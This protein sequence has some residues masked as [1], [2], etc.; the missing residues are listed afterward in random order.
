[1]RLCYPLIRENRER[2]RKGRGRNSGKYFSFVEDVSGDEVGIK[3]LST[4]CCVNLRFFFWGG[5]SM[6]ILQGF[7]THL[8]RLSES[9]SS[10]SFHG[11]VMGMMC[12]KPRMMIDS[13]LCICSAKRKMG[14]QRMRE[15]YL[16]YVLF[17]LL[18]LF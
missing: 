3:S 12:H 10:W 18:D 9:F 11:P 15:T 7:I 5:W 6:V 16:F 4:D 2:T 14:N 1:M 8:S 13:I 17:L